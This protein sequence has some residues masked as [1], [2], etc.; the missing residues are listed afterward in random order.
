[1]TLSI[2]WN[3][4]TGVTISSGLL[5]AAI[6]QEESSISCHPH[7]RVIMVVLAGIKVLNDE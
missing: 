3:L 5:V 2:D 4:C 1:M 6:N 7:K